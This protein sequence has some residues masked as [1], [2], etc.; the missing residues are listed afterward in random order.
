M[1]TIKTTLFLIILLTSSLSFS[2]GA[3]L[4]SDPVGYAQLVQNASNTLQTLKTAKESYEMA[5]DIYT[6]AKKVN[7]AFKSAKVCGQILDNLEGTY[8]NISSVPR[9][10]NSIEH[11]TIR[12]NLLRA[13]DDLTADVDVFSE[14]SATVVSDNVLSMNDAERLSAITSL[15][16]KSKDLREKSEQLIKVINRSK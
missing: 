6:T 14:L 15:Y 1:K 9:L 3:M 16:Q 11:S 8:N 5:K 2:Q 12:K 7:D 10:I 4:V 13:T